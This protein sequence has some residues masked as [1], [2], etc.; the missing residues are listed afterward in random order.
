VKKENHVFVG[1]VKGCISEDGYPVREMS[2]SNRPGQSPCSGIRLFFLLNSFI[3][4]FSCLVP[5]FSPICHFFFSLSCLSFAVLFL[6]LGPIR[7]YIPPI[8]SQY[9]LIFPKNAIMKYIMLL[10][11]R[12]CR[13]HHGISSKKTSYLTPKYCEN[14][15]NYVWLNQL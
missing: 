14:L 9:R 10:Q 4:L 5:T 12:W 2:K 7:N 1:P 8:W 15:I 6:W 3:W 11:S 13:Y